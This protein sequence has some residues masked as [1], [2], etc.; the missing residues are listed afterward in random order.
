VFWFSLQLL[1]ETFHLLRR[2]QRDII[3]HL[4]RFS[5]KNTRYSS[6]ILLKLEISRQFFR[7]I[8]QYQISWKSVHW[9]PSCYLRKEITKPTVAFH[10]F[11]N[12]MLSKQRWGCVSSYVLLKSAVFVSYYHITQSF[13]KAGLIPQRLQ[14]QA[15]VTLASLDWYH[16]L[17]EC[18]K[19]CARRSVCFCRSGW[20]RCQYWSA[21]VAAAVTWLW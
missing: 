16:K 11:A 18:A 8:R 10:S 15:Q 6:Q 19:S 14:L 5:C 13:S 17:G 4:P 7:K 2:I 20:W 21:Y 12:V 1:S 3:I 9:E